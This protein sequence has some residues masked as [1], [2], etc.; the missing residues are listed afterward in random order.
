MTKDDLLKIKKTLLENDNV[1]I[2]TTNKKTYLEGTAAF[3]TKKQDMIR[4]YEGDEDGSDD[5]D[6]TLDEFLENYYFELLVEFDDE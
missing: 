5:K 2:L 4:V 1:T 6:L 3:L